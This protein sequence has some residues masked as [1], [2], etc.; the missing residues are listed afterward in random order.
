MNER[1]LQILSFFKWKSRHQFLI[2]IIEQNIQ[3]KLNALLEGRRLGEIINF[4]VESVEPG[5]LIKQK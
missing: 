1:I 5:S 2:N 4:I 3:A